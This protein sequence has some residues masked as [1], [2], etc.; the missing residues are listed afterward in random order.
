MGTFHAFFFTMLNYAGSLLQ[1]HRYCFS[2]SHLDSP[3]AV[4]C[5]NDTMMCAPQPGQEPG[6]QGSVRA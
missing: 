3:S 6:M 4:P 1:A 2:S 5:D